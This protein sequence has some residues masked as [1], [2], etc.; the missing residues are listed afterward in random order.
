MFDGLRL[1]GK[2]EFYTATDVTS[3]LRK[4][5]VL[6]AIPNRPCKICGWTR[7]P[8]WLVGTPVSLGQDQIT[9]VLQ[10]DDMSDTLIGFDD[11]DEEEP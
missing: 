4:G 5:E 11:E 1:G 3:F 10:K 8:Y 7:S 9:F 6:K 2:K